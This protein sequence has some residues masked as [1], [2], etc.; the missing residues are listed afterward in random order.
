[1]SLPLGQHQTEIER[2]RRAWES[3]PLLRE[4]YASFYRRILGLMDRSLPGRVVEIGSGI[5][6][7]KSHLP[8]AIT[9]DL[10]PN[11]WLDLV[12][13]GYELPFASGSLSHLILFDVLHHLQRPNAFLREARRA[14]REDGRLILFEPFI[15]WSSLPVY[16][17]LHHE[18][19]GL[20]RPIDLSDA[21]PN[22]RDYYAA[23]GNA[24]RLFFRRGR[25][26]P[27]QSSRIEPLN[28][29][30]DALLRVQ[31]DRQVGPTTFMEWADTAI[32]P[33]TM[34]AADQ[35]VGTQ[36]VTVPVADKR[37]GRKPSA[38]LRAAR[39]RDACGGLE[40]THSRES[41]LAAALPG[42]VPVEDD[43]TRVRPVAEAGKEVRV[44]IAVDVEESHSD[45]TPVRPAAREL[46]N[47]SA[48]RQ[49]PAI[50]EP[51]ASRVF[52]AINKR[53]DAAFEQVEITVAVEVHE[54]V[55][56]AGGNFA[57]L[58]ILH[59]L[60]AIADQ[61]VIASG[62]A[63]PGLNGVE[64]HGEIRASQVRQDEVDRH[65]AGAEEAVGAVRHA[66]GGVGQSDD[67]HRVLVKGPA[68][69]LGAKGLLEIHLDGRGRVEAW[70]AS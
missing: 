52:V 39:E 59:E 14:L 33:A 6:N 16:G 62:L 4:I 26:L 50:H 43:F 49:S 13:D 64:V 58:E 15:S 11:P 8:E 51:V 63:A 27:S 32:E 10:F 20:G 69:V 60:V 29:G 2:N 41:E 56:V 42:D 57:A 19:V 38:R 61:A 34:V 17:L 24:T 36:A 1:M 31:A 7:L 40:R 54:L 48:R 68:R 30:R 22:P 18:P 53:L 70:A 55:E 47:L 67:L 65:L 12:C 37:D 44:A 66:A 21:A 35:R 5:G 23:Q 45:P 25:I 28:R 46:E 3:K 9:T